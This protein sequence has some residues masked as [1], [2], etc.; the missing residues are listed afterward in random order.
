MTRQQSSQGLSCTVICARL[1]QDDGHIFCLPEQLADEIR[2]T[3]DLVENVMAAFG[4][5]Q[6]EVWSVCLRS[7]T[8]RILRLFTDCSDCQNR[9]AKRPFQSAF[10]TANIADMMYLPVHLQQHCSWAMIVLVEQY[11]LHL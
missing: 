8:L 5:V 9:D 3:L 1:L 4:F 7:L 6:L 2:G 10:V 11:L